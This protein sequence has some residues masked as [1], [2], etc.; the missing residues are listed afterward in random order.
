MKN[1]FCQTKYDQ[2]LTSPYFNFQRVQMTVLRLH[3]PRL[4]MFEK[5]TQSRSKLIMMQKLSNLLPKSSIQGLEL[6]IG[7]SKINYL[8]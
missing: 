7:K 1:K 4:E 3:T 8:F 5:I 2:M 6:E